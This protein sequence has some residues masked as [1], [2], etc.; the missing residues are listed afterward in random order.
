MNKVIIINL[1]GNAYQLEENGYEALRAYLDTASRR[2]EGNPD[3]D[4]IMADIEQAIADKFR[5]LL[6]ASKTVVATREVEGVIAEM[7]PVE[8]ASQTPAAGPRGAGEPPKAATPQGETHGPAKRLY[9]IN[10]GAMLAGVCN[11][12]AAHFNIDVS[13]VRIVFLIL[14]LTYGA[15]A[16]LYVIMAFLIPPAVTPVEKAAATGAPS[17]A[18][19]FIRRARAGYYEGMK[20]FGDRRAYREWKRNF[21]HEMRG[22]RQDLTREVSQS[23]Q[24][25]ACNWRQHWTHQPHPMLGWWIAVPFL[26]LLSALVALLCLFALVSL[27]ATGAVFGILLPAGIPVWAGLIIVILVFQI[28]ALPLKVMRHMMYYRVG[29]DPVCSGWLHLW[30]AIALLGFIALLLWFARLHSAQ[31]HDAIG[32]LPHEIHR[33]VDSFRAW[34][35]RP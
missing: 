15:G 6:G 30:N 26:R 27:L 28:I 24:Q 7:G 19:E 9:R 12:L 2:L 31:V 8:D 18:Q 22:W 20:A 23:A 14:T 16:L 4:E 5:A 32:N 33:A 3:R 21:R 1:N 34:W 35:S 11:G 25:W 29:Y 17:T 13:I 10:D